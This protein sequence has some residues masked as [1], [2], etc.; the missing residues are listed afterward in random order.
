MLLA[1]IRSTE[2]VELTAAG[3]TLAEARAALFAKAPAG[4]EVTQAHNVKDGDAVTI[5]GSAQST[6]FREIEADDRAA[7][8]AQVGD[9][10]QYQ[11]IRR[12]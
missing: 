1:T 4:Y 8:D 7:L 11:S 9:G 3:A 2:T 10:W 12:L 5:T 6:E